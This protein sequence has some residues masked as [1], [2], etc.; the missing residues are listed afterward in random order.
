[1]AQADGGLS[2]VLVVD[3]AAVARE[4]VAASS[5]PLVTYRLTPIEGAE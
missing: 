1:M 3:A 4:I 5:R 2:A